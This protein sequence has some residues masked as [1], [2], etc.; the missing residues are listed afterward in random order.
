M[1]SSQLVL[2]QVIEDFDLPSTTPKTFYGVARALNALGFTHTNL[3]AKARKEPLDMVFN[4]WTMEII[5]GPYRGRVVE[6]INGL[7]YKNFFKSVAPYTAP[8][9]ASRYHIRFVL[10]LLRFRF[11]ET[12]KISIRGLGEITPPTTKCLPMSDPNSVLPTKT[13]IQGNRL[14]IKDFVDDLTGIRQ[15]IEKVRDDY[16]EWVIDLGGGGRR[17]EVAQI[18]VAFFDPDDLPKGLYGSRVRR[19]RTVWASRGCVETDTTFGGYAFQ[20][21]TPNLPTYQG[22]IKIIIGGG[23]GS[24][25]Y[26]FAAFT[27]LLGGKWKIIKD[28]YVVSRRSSRVQLVA[29]SD[30]NRVSNRYNGEDGGHPT[31]SGLKRPNLTW[32]NP[33]QHLIGYFLVGR[34]DEHVL[35]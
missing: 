6:S 16:D 2:G 7:G 19:P 21:L 27:L 25:S 26:V 13:H 3:R 14:Y 11:P 15:A 29:R 4:P 30:H 9:C 1:V 20:G 34:R 33:H 32:E 31:K 28:K 22:K 17:E 12:I 5:S 18:L 24:A 8:G 35:S 23:V 10:E